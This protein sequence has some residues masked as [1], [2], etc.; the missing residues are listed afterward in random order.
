MLGVQQNK[1][2]SKVKRLGGGFGGKESKAALIAIPIAVAARKIN[3]PLRCMLDRDEDII[4]TGA[5]HP[6]MFK[7]KIA[8]DDNG[9]F[10]GVDAEIYCN[11]GYASD[12]SLSVS[13]IMK[14]CN[15]KDGVFLP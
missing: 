12:L 1:I 14:R 3:R 4:M 8:V 9:K 13:T 11:A 7:Y 10:L 6:F 15:N 5:R 2:I